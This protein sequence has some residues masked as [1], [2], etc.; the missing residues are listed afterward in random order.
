MSLRH[1]FLLPAAFSALAVLM[2]CG[3]T[4]G[5]S[6]TNPTPPPSGSFSNSNLNGSYVFSVS[7]IDANGAPYAIAGILTANGNG[8]ITGGAIDVNDASFSAPVAATAINGNSTYGVGVDGRG[9]ISLGT[10]PLGTVT[11]DFVLQDSTHGYVI[12]FDSNATGSGT[13]DL[14]SANTTPT[15]SYAFSFTG[16]DLSSSSFSPNV[17]ATVGNFTVGSGGAIAGLEDFNDGAAASAGLTLNG[18]LALGPSQSPS[19]VFTSGFGTLTFD[20]FAIDATHLKFIEM[21]ASG[22]LSGD[23]YAQADTTFPT[24]TVAFTMSGDYPLQSTPSA[25]GG[26]FV[27]DGSGNITTASS[28][29]YNAGGSASS[30]PASF[31]G[32]YAG[33]GTGRY[34][35]GVTNF[36]MGSSFV[37]YPSSGGLLM[38]EIDNSGI[39]I[40]GAYP[41]TLN[42]AFSESD[43]YGLNLTGVNLVAGTGSFGGGGP[44]EVDDIAE[45]VT[46]SNGA[47]V[48]GVVD[49]NYQPGGFTN[50]GVALSGNYTL[51]DSTGRGGIGANAGNGY[52]GTLNGGFGITFYTV[53]GTIFPFIETDSNGQVAAGAFF[54]QNPSAAIPVAAKSHMFVVP[55]LIRPRSAIR[56]RQ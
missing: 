50:F 47:T 46:N 3:G 38:L 51:P 9:R 43:G 55:T 22:N 8:G 25:A 26:F 12:E 41:Q 5:G 6:F 24:G 15:G 28:A 48:T 35:V 11:L 27:T 40:G 14:Q 16:A 21:D 17:L 19:T 29:D 53:D 42:A 44:V 34:T 18:T 49:E 13:L 52:N 7:G 56:K 39:M 4:P 30:T 1:R 20:V 31:S 33:A 32:T 36:L 37:A 23:A 10:V 2:S 54:K 45:F